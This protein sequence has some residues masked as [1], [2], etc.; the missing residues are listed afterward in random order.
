MPSL[1]TLLL[2]WT[3]LVTHQMKIVQAMYVILYFKMYVGFGP[4]WFW[5]IWGC[6][7]LWQLGSILWSAVHHILCDCIT[8]GHCLCNHSVCSW[9]ACL[10]GLLWWWQSS[11]CQ[12][13]VSQ[14]TNLP[15]CGQLSSM[16]VVLKTVAAEQE[17]ILIWKT[18]FQNPI[19]YCVMF[20]IISIVVMSSDVYL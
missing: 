1:N 7:N 11:G 19:A 6:Q 5:S 12:S 15:R 3:L 14:W 16:C 17:H 9:L 4:Q 2:M 10:Q 18:L 13:S 20:S 8:W